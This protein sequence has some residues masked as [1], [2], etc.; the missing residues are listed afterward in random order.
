MAE[1]QPSP[2]TSNL[3]LGAHMND[4]KYMLDDF[5]KA[6]EDCAVVEKPAKVEGRALTMVLTEKRG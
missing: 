1:S 4:S 5:A 2:Q 3:A 6:L